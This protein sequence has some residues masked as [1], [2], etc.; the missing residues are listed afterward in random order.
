MY[1]CFPVY[2]AAGYVEKSCKAKAPIPVQV[3]S[4]IITLTKAPVPRED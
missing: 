1:I 4:T 2:S 3:K